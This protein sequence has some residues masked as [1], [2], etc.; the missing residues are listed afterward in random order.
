MRHTL[1]GCLGLS[2]IFV[3]ACDD[4]CGN[5]IVQDLRSPG[6]GS[7]A[8]VF[9]RDCGATT[10][11]STQISILPA[12]KKLSNDPGNVFVA[13]GDKNG[14]PLDSHGAMNLEIEWKGDH[15]L[16]IAYS[17]GAQ[18]FLKIS[19]VNGTRIFYAFH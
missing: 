18:V 15:E 7:H 17:S 4:L 11:L 16:Y 13:T 1:T 2:L 9:V 5:Q 12:N 10:G 8:V 6:G 14:L 3:A 19:E